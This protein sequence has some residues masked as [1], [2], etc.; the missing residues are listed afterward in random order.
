MLVSS[1]RVLR[2]L[3]KGTQLPVPTLTLEVDLGVGPLLSGLPVSS[4]IGIAN[5]VRLLGYI[6]VRDLL[7]DGVDRLLHYLP[8]LLK[9]VLLGYGAGRVAKQHFIV[10]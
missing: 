1:R 2:N 5:F 4:P 7:S 6:V 10:N 9:D 3:A 8:I